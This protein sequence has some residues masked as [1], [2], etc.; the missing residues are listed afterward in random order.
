MYTS[1]IHGHLTAKKR[2]KI[3]SG[4]GYF[5]LNL[6]HEASTL[7]QKR[8]TSIKIKLLTRKFTKNLPRRTTEILHKFKLFNE[9]KKN[10][11][12]FKM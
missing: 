8:V 1:L 7:N 10:N 4:I 2:N 11:V 5:I 3:M 12:M 6:K 9:W